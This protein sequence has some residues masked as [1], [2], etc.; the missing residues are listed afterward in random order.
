MPDERG[1]HRAQPFVRGV[2]EAGHHGVDELLLPGRPGRRSSRHLRRGRC[3]PRRHAAGRSSAARDRPAVDCSAGPPGSTSSAARP[4]GRSSRR[5]RSRSARGA[6]SAVR[7]SLQT[8]AASAAPSAAAMR[9]GVRRE[10]R[11]E[12]EH[13]RQHDG[14]RRRVRQPERSAQ[15]VADLVVHARSGR[16]ERDRGEVAAEEGLLGRVAVAGAH[17]GQPG[18]RARNPSIASAASIGSTRGAHIA[19]TQWATALSPDATREF[20]WQPVEQ[21]DVVDDRGR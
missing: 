6:S 8:A 18:R 7:S 2:G 21:L 17:T 12:G 11:V 1:Q 20:G 9:R 14:V 19:S 5:P 16:R 10:R 3:P 13:V 4:T 15:H